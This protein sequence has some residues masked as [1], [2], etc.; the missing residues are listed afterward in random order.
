MSYL[1]DDKKI[2]LKEL[3]IQNEDIKRENESIELENRAFL[4]L[5]ESYEDGTKLLKVLPYL[6][7][8]CTSLYAVEEE[9]DF[10][11]TR[12]EFAYQL[13]QLLDKEIGRYKNVLKNI[14]T[15]S[16]MEGTSPTTGLCGH[17]PTKEKLAKR[18]YSTDI[19]DMISV[20]RGANTRITSMREQSE[21]KDTPGGA[22]PEE[23]H[24]QTVEQPP[25]PPCQ[26]IEKNICLHWERQE[27]TGELYSIQSSEAREDIHRSHLN[28]PE[29]QQLTVNEIEKLKGKIK[30]NTIHYDNAKTMI[31]SM[32]TQCK[33]LLFELDEDIKTYNTWKERMKNDTY[34]MK[35]KHCLSEFFSDIVQKHRDKVG[36]AKKTNH[37]LLNLYKKK[38]STMNYIISI[39]ENINNVDFR[40][41][42]VLIHNQKLH[43]DRL[44]REH[45]DI[46]ACLRNL[47]NELRQTHNKIEEHEERKKEMQTIIEKNNCTLNEMDKM[48]IDLTNKIDTTNSV[49]NK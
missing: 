16:V 21:G 35:R 18:L 14:L 12:H 33:I 15:K 13:N 3:I 9:I 42:H 2:L 44:M 8:V 26:T 24:D 29:K 49:S 31:I 37:T 28:L 6:H 10:N 41:L 22:T 40:Y 39:N 30:K 47:L 46:Y 20:S 36:E 27:P 17:P 45:E 1:L 11:L 23:E 5:I 32:I 43:Y 19:D 4:K 7:H 48:I 38:L 25:T 34:I